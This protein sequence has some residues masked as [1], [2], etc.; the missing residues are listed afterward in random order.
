MG[1]SQGLGGSSPSLTAMIKIILFRHGEKQKV[2]F[3]GNKKTI[4]CLS[5]SGVKQITKLGKTLKTKFPE[6]KNCQYLY[7][8]GFSRTIQS[9]EIVRNILGIPEI[10]SIPEFQEFYPVT[11]F[12]IAKNIRDHLFA[13]AMIDPDWV[14]P[15]VNVSFNQH[16]S[17]FQSKIKE[18]CQNTSP[19]II[20]ISSHGEIIRNLVYS[21]NPQLKPSDDVIF[22]SK[23]HEAG[24]T[25]LN[26]DGQN[27]TV[28]Q[29]DVH[30]H[31]K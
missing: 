23:I 10:L 18:I 27:F 2:E 21:L 5:N 14:P 28:D 9:A 7:T 17:T 22:D 16:I 12:S 19:K 31:L 20:L 1:R 30:D 25:I 3:N 11:D 8:S 26:F 15:E 13:Q 24:Y 29:F 4:T 6:L